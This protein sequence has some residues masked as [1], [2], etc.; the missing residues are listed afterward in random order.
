MAK[1]IIASAVRQIKHIA[2]FDE[3]IKQ[4]MD[5]IDMNALFVYMV[6]T[7]DSKALIYL[8]DQFDVLGFKGWALAQTDP[9]KRELIKSAIELHKHKGT[10]FAIRRAISQ[11]IS[12]IQYN[13]ITIQERVNLGGIF[14]N[15]LFYRNGSRFRGQ[16]HWTNFRVFIDIAHYGALTVDIEFL[17]LQLIL[18]YKNERSHLLNLSFGFQ[19]EENFNAIDE[20][21]VNVGEDFPE[22]LDVSMLHDGEHLRDGSRQRQQDIFEILISSSCSPGV[23]SPTTISN[24]NIPVNG[25]NS[26]LSPT[27]VKKLLLD[28]TFPTVQDL[29]ILLISP[30][31]Y[32]TGL[33]NSGAG[34]IS[35]ANFTNTIFWNDPLITQALSASSAP[36]T[37]DFNSGWLTAGFNYLNGA[38]NGM[39]NIAI[40]NG[41]PN[42]GTLNS[43][44]L[45]FNY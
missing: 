4:R 14:H 21:L 31:G 15:G 24:F 27:Q 6:D 13:D 38:A 26:P 34:G 39:W 30:D 33:T 40:I 17:I 18:A 44:T 23:I 25:V 9:E 12:A 5:G 7:V 32:I 45:T 29:I 37:G 28:I 11:A 16:T 43:G 20:F 8:A 1:K 10:A 22:E 2:D 41:G 36:Y 19:T 42:S 35:G 3:L